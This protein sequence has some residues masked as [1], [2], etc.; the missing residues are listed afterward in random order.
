MRAFIT[1]NAGSGKSLFRAAAEER[2][3]ELGCAAPCID[4]DKACKDIARQAGIALPANPGDAFKSL[5][6]LRALEEQFLPH[7]DRLL[8]VPHVL[9][10]ASSLIEQ[11]CFI[12]PGDFVI[13]ISCAQ[14]KARA[15]S[16]DASARRAELVEKCQISAQARPLCCDWNIS[17]DGSPDDLRRSARAC[18]DSFARLAGP[19][20]ERLADDC[21]RLMLA[22]FSGERELAAAVLKAYASPSRHFH[23]LEHLA[24]MR[25]FVER[26]PSFA[27]LDP[28][29]RAAVLLALWFHDF[30]MAFAPGAPNEERS[31]QSLF[32]LAKS[33]GA[34]GRLRFGSRSPVSLAV[35]LILAT[36]TH[37]ALAPILSFGEGR[38]AAGCLLDADMAVL[39]AEPAGYALY[40]G[41]IR[42]EWAH[43]SD[44]DFRQGR[45]AFLQSLASDP[46]GLFILPENQS[47]DAPARRNAAD[48]LNELTKAH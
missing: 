22:D 48:E 36:K 34:L 38:L 19:E 11:A 2:L 7:L 33:T 37:K 3:A 28:L 46:A 30:D 43:F 17:N 40:R 10:E 39:A 8:D 1:G 15:A 16:R 42:S 21:L 4:L 23:G 13:G 27:K 20:A 32:A 6:S 44:A 35:E 29:W 18:A 25:S 12:R 45:C 31:A 26:L 9:A 14:S 41:Q 5:A 47:L 24:A